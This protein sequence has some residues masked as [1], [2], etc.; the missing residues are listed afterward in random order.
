VHAVAQRTAPATRRDGAIERTARNTTIGFD[1]NVATR[2]AVTRVTHR[3][4]SPQPAIGAAR[5]PRGNTCARA[6]P[7]RSGAE[8][9]PQTGTIAASISSMRILVVDDESLLARCLQRRLKGHDVAI[10]LDITVALVCVEVAETD[11]VP[12]DVVLCDYQMPGGG[13]LDLFATLRQRAAPPVLLLMTGLQVVTGA[14]SACD[15]ILSKPFD[16]AEVFVAVAYAQ[17]LRAHK[18]TMKMRRARGSTA[19]LPRV[20]SEAAT[21]PV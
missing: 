18:Q 11:G 4:R 3:P 7:A 6:S 21:R 10:A 12:F 8:T 16:V 2:V 20:E 19:E 1:A 14:E 5:N 17:A 13:G 15:A 9:A